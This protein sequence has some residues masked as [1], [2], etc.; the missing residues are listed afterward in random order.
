MKIKSRN[1]SF[2][3]KK[4]FLE[5]KLELMWLRIYHVHQQKTWVWNMFISYS[6]ALRRRRSS[7][8]EEISKKGSYEH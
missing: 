6:L 8:F 1:F 2:S 4:T 5:G 3:R 7:Y